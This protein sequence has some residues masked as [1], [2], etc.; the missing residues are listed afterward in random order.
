[1]LSGGTTH[2][3]QTRKKHLGDKHTG[4]Q[5]LH[6]EQNHRSVAHST[7]NSSTWASHVSVF[8][9]TERKKKVAKA[10]H[11]CFSHDDRTHSESIQL[12]STLITRIY[13]LTSRDVFSPASYELRTKQHN[14]IL[15]N[16]LSG[17]WHV[18]SGVDQYGSQLH[19]KARHALVDLTSV[20]LLKTLLQSMPKKMC[21]FKGFEH[22]FREC[23]KNIVWEI[24]ATPQNMVGLLQRFVSSNFR[25]SFFLVHKCTLLTSMDFLKNTPPPYLNP[26]LHRHTMVIA[27][28]ALRTELRPK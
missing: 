20:W 10:Y 18:C 26:D 1:M 9:P 14:L 7:T 19:K 3:S 24:V 2:C 22:C 13:D 21:N 17:T 23:T 27:P 4:S 5:G 11:C 15:D 8:L 28:S 16:S 12:R 25:E 6:P